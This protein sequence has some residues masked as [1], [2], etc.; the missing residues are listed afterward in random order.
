MKEKADY[1]S[2]IFPFEIFNSF[3]QT[4]EGGPKREEAENMG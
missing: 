3:L 1:Q 2:C 4:G